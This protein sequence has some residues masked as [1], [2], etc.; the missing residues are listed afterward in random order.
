MMTGFT[1]LPLDQIH[2]FAKNIQNV[3]DGHLAQIINLNVHIHD[4]SP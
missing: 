4:T 1:N 3:N 2:H